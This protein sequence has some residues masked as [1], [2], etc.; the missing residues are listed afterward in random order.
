M[1]SVGA[2]NFIRNGAIAYIPANSS[3]TEIVSLTQQAQLTFSIPDQELRKASSLKISID[4]GATHTFDISYASNMPGE[5]GSWQDIEEISE[6]LNSGTIKNSSNQTLQSLGMQASGKSGNLTISLASGVF[7]SD[8]SLQ[9]LSSSIGNTRA[10]IKTR[11]TASDL[12]IFT[13]EGRHISGSPL[14]DEEVN[15]L[16]TSA[17][18]FSDSAQYRADYLNGYGASGYRGIKV[19]RTNS[20][21]GL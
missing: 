17:N 7:N 21:A 12:Q 10:N 16:M 15:I 11:T 20:K 8:Q 13:K 14:T 1:S 4:G 9:L 2:S 18:G 6:R 19:E 3:A 5:S